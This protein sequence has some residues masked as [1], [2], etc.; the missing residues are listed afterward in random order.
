[1][2]DDD[3]IATAA[4]AI[5]RAGTVVA[6]TGAGVSTASGIPDFRSE[7]G[8][9]DRYDPADFRLS[10]FESDP[11]GF[12]R[13][14]ADLVEELH[15]DVA[16]NAAHEAL[17]GLERDG[18]LDALI[19]QNVDGLHA[20]AGS[21]DP[22]ELHGTGERVVCRECDRRFDATPAYESARTGD[23]PPR[24]RDC[25]G[26]LKPDVVLFGERLPGEAIERARARARAADCVLVAGTSLTVEPAAS[27]PRTAVETGAALVVVD[28][29]PTPVSDLAD[30]DLRAD[31]TDA[32]PR[33]RAAVADHGRS[34]R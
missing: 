19:T 3:A 30:V 10:R 20:Q 8:V 27:L 2:T 16:P 6:L 1:V 28:R 26:V 23:V 7:G 31:V 22:I 32:L 33:L 13:D 11:A 17:A 29:E 12:W 21:E 4:E 9:W 15:G 14:R 25:G 18:H 5:R 24:C 34:D